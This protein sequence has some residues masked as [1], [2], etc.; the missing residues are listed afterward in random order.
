MSGFPSCA[1]EDQDR[2][3]RALL[4]ERRLSGASAARIDSYLLGRNSDWSL[5]AL[6]LGAVAMMTTDD[7]D[8]ADD[9]E[10]GMPGRK[11]AESGEHASETTQKGEAAGRRADPLA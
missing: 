7:D 10:P 4:R 2:S 9:D 1:V 6:S 11:P 3:D 8:P 5:V